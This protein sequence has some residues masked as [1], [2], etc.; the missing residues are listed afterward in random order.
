MDKNDTNQ[1]SSFEKSK[2]VDRMVEILKDPKRLA[3]FEKA[4]TN[5]L[6]AKGKSSPTMRRAE[7]AFRMFRSGMGKELLTPRNVLILGAALLYLISPL[8][9][10]PDL[11]PIIGLLDD[12]GILSMVLAIVIPSF[13]ENKTEMTPAEQEELRK[14]AEI[15]EEEAPQDNAPKDTFDFG[16]WVRRFTERLGS[17][18]K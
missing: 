2:W 11:M 8:D 5:F 17:S 7:L 1:S 9:A 18:G 10:I 14:E 13:L 15:I 3:D 6:A 12:L 16:A 4:V